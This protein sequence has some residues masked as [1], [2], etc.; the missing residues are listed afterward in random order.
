L[1]DEISTELTFPEFQR[2]MGRGLYIELVRHA[3][4][5]AA[6][7]AYKS[8]AVSG[9]SI[10][11]SP[12]L[13][14]LSAIPKN[15]AA[16]VVNDAV[17]RLAIPAALYADQTIIRDSLTHYFIAHAARPDP[18]YLY[19]LTSALTR[20]KPLIRTGVVAFRAF[21]DFKLCVSRNAS[22]WRDQTRQLAHDIVLERRA[23][24]KARISNETPGDA[25][26]VRKQLLVMNAVLH[27][28]AGDYL[29]FPL[30][31]HQVE[32]LGGRAV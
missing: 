13:N 5:S 1:L 4:W 8:G 3:E 23:G 6:H 21:N 15:P 17:T 2:R 12:S 31:S 10:L 16:S 25:T 29:D 19:A 28:Q 7:F 24:F 14:P 32:T 9:F 20:L 27:G 30:S 11:P 18:H 26:S 22:E